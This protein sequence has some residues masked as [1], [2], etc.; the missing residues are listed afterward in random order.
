MCI[1]G[2]STYMETPAEM[3]KGR[4]PYIAISFVIFALYFVAQ[5]IETSGIYET[6]YKATNG[7]DVRQV[8]LRVYELSWKGPVSRI[9]MSLVLLLGDGLLVL[10]LSLLTWL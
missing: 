2:L 3:K 4:K 5:C 1:Y 10:G 7:V 6:L 9:L 8:G